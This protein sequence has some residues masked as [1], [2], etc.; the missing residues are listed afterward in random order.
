[1]A[2]D[3]ISLH[4]RCLGG[5]GFEF[6]NLPNPRNGH[7]NLGCACIEALVLLKP[8]YFEDA[9][10][11]LS[12][13][14]GGVVSA[15]AEFSLSN[16]E[17]YR[18]TSVST[19]R[20]VPRPLLLSGTQKSGT[21]WLEAIIN[22]DNRALVIH[23]ANFLN[24]AD[25]LAIEGYLSERDDFFSEDNYV[26]W[27]PIDV[28]RKDYIHLIQVGVLK[29]MFD[30]FGRMG[31]YELIADRTPHYSDRYISALKYFPELKI[32]HIVRH[33]LDVLVSWTFHEANAYVGMG[34]RLKGNLLSR[35]LLKRIVEKRHSDSFLLG[36]D[37][38][39]FY[40]EFDGLLKDW[41]DDQ[42]HALR[43]KEAYPERLKVIRY[44]DLTENFD[45]EVSKLYAFLG[46]SLDVNRLRAIGD[47]TS[48][49]AMSGGRTRGVKDASS[50]FR[51]GQVEDYLKH[52]SYAQMEFCWALTGRVAEQFGYS[53]RK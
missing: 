52:L 30:I 49:T 46:L 37:D 50:F 4:L 29:Q 23:E 13:I 20:N 5:S 2:H 19:R 11:E 51:S 24:L 38:D 27:K 43:A 44:E 41:T 39:F 1:M 25:T 36:S 53:L 28:S 45:D 14:C 17:I 26:K 47:A 21:T 3:H 34:D 18:K 35:Q 40:G 6:F 8:D 42:M 15:S 12:L 10:F 22:H 48:F 16:G 32:V 31:D 9:D 33:P 7:N